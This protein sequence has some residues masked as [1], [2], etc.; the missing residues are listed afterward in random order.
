MPVLLPS[1]DWTAWLSPDA[2]A[3]TIAPMLAP[4][5]AKLIEAW[6][7]ARKVSSGR[8]DGAELIEPVKL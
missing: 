3:Q 4:A 5:D 8:E 1:S 2:D 7:V 6:P